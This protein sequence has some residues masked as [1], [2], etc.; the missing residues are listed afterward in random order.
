VHAEHVGDPEHSVLPRAWEFEIV[1][2]RLEREPTDGGEPFLDLAL[3]RGAER[4]YLRFWSPVELEIERGGP[5]M[6]GGLI[7]KDIRGRHL[8]GLGVRVD[9]LE[10]SRGA[11]RFY[12]RTVEAIPEPAAG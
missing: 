7:I 10:A 8:E 6:T 3:R 11:I 1:G 2:V 5:Q 12:A 4:R 9:D